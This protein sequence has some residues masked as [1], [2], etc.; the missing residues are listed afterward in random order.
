MPPLLPRSHV[1]QYWLRWGEWLS[2]RVSLRQTSLLIATLTTALVLLIQQSG[3]LQPLELLAFDQL[4]RGQSYSYTDPRFL[5]VTITETDLKTQQQWPLKDETLARVLHTLQ[6]YQPRVI[7]LNLYRDLPL[8]P[9]QRQLQQEL[10]ASNLIGVNKL[11][12]PNMERVLPPPALPA[13]RVGFN[14]LVLDPDGVVRRNFLFAN[15][16]SGLRYSFSL[17]LALAYGMAAT[18]TPLDLRL[19]PTHLP[20]LPDQGGGYA[21]IDTTGYQVLVDHRSILHAEQVSL[22]QVLAG[23]LTVDQVRDR[24]VLIG[25]T[26][27]S[28][29]GRVLTPHSATAQANPLNS[30]LWL[31]A[32][33][34]AQLLQTLLG[35]QTLPRAL[36]HWGGILWMSLW[37]WIGATLVLSCPSLLCLLLRSLIASA[38]LGICAALALAQNLWIPWVAPTLSFLM[39]LIAMV[40]Y[41]TFHNNFHDPLTGLPNRSRFLQGLHFALN[42][43]SSRPILGS[44]SASGAGLSSGH[45]PSASVASDSIS[46]PAPRIAVLFIA[47]NRFGLVNDTFGYATGDRLLLQ[48]RD[49]IQRCLLP[50]STTT[51]GLLP[52]SPKSPYLL[53]RVGGDEFGLLL[54]DTATSPETPRSAP[55]SPPVPT[56]SPE[57]SFTQRAI[58]LAEHI[59][60][61]LEQSLGGEAPPTGPDSDTQSIVLVTASIGI[62]FAPADGTQTALDVLRD[63]HAA[64]YRAKSLGHS[65]YEVFSVGLHAEL[66]R[67]LGLEMNLRQAIERQE[68]QVY[69]QPIVDLRTH[70][71]TGFEA[72]V[73]WWHPQQG[74]MSP[75]EF[76][77]VAEDSGLIIPLD[78]WVLEQACEQLQR[79]RTHWTQTHPQQALNVILNVNLSTKQFSRA[80]IVE[81]VADILQRTG[82][83]GH[84][85]KLEIT[86][87]VA[88]QDNQGLDPS[89]DS[90]PET[91][92]ESHCIDTM[93]ALKELDIR[94]SLDD[95]GTGY[96]A[97]NYLCRFP[98]DT[99]KI[100]KSFVSR[101]PHGQADCILIKNII[102]LSHDLGINV[103][104]EGI[105]TPEQV[106]LLQQWSCDYGQGYL[107]SKPLSAEVAQTWLDR[108]LPANAS[109]SP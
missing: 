54:T 44:S 64:M 105:E 89:P 51:H 102:N 3:F 71:L 90:K 68:L 30:S 85:L 91:R 72:L 18:D 108:T 52:P 88:L 83:P 7:G 22:S 56:A 25:T 26:A 14:D 28:L 65:H 10:Q 24:I 80:N 20:Q 12:D 1:Q 98:I 67:K 23:E 73:R 2:D 47:L 97:L 74:F 31:Q 19:T 57:S 15:L 62:V 38:G 21:Q 84:Y 41:Q 106:A 66:T 61:T 59:S 53:A 48:A 16:P 93:L 29:A 45:R 43:P 99:L 39:A 50:P 46:S 9:G 87:R 94:F 42:H 82:L 13:D 55:A 103:T 17:R 5:L 35:Q 40:L 58:A 86:E 77:E 76:V 34:T 79:W 109:V 96:S 11:P 37:G 92:L 107:F 78:Q 75:A 81:T 6:Q 95:F 8:P 69:Y 49:Q 36:P 27:T 104:A 101:M 60:R 70:T 4:V 100:D 32:Q 33:L 63:A